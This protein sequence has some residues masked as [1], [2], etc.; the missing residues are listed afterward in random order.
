MA[1][2][3]LT[4]ASSL[5][6][7]LTITATITTLTASS[8]ASSATVAATLVKCVN[9]CSR[10]L[11][12]RVSVVAI[13]VAISIT[14]IIINYLGKFPKVVVVLLNVCNLFLIGEHGVRGVNVNKVVL[15]VYIECILKVLDLY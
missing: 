4:S 5:T 8:L 11:V 15:D 9:L 7:T 12:Y 14:I 6:I 2:A 13:T 10:F 3:L 1:S